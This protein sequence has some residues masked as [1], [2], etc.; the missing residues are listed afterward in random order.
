ML[1]IL[2]IILTLPS[3][4]KKKKQVGPLGDVTL[5]G[6]N[7]NIEGGTNLYWD[8]LV[9][10]LDNYRETTSSYVYYFSF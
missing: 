2:L 6:I 3:E 5:S 10:H 7:F 9:R 8:D 1:K 4:K